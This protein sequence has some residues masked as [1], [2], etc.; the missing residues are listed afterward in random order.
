MAA[1]LM[2]HMLWFGTTCP[3]Y[4]KKSVGAVK[5]F[6]LEFIKDAFV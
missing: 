5:D 1:S 2:T 6:D 3:E 4:E